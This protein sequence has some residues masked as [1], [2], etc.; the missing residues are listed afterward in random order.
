MTNVCTRPLATAEPVLP[1]RS[2]RTAM[3][4]EVGT[5]MMCLFLFFVLT[6]ASLTKQIYQASF[7]TFQTGYAS[8]LSV[9]LGL[10]LFVCVIFYVRKSIDAED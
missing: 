9:L 2:I 3:A 1:V 8:S 5:S 6:V 7:G 4:N 10:C